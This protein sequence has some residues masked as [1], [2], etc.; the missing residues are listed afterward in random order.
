M[1]KPRAMEL[2]L[3]LCCGT[4]LLAGCRS[5]SDSSCPAPTIAIDPE[6]IPNGD[7]DTLVT[8]TARS[9]ARRRCSVRR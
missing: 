3:V 6:T 5:G 4:L 1:L 2:L 9:V 8:V 7:N